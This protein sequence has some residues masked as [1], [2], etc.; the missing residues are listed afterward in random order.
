MDDNREY[1]LAI[2]NGTQSVRA[3][4][5]DLHGELVAKS[6]V[7]IEPY[8]SEQPGWAE[9]H[10]EYF[11]DRLCEACHGLWP[12]LDFPLSAIKSVALTTQRAT[13]VNLDADGRPLRPAIVWLDQR[14]EDELPGMGLWGALLTL[15]GERETVRFFR[16]QAEANWIRNRQPDIWEKTDKLLLLSGYLSY[17][18]TGKFVDSV[19][20]QVGYIPFDFKRHK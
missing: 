18:L 13:V 19:A 1:V 12:Q 15:A 4:V 11:W 2:D 5:F 7:E 17:R 14:L 8:F 16:R 20:S 9:Q 6:K 10:V 3:L